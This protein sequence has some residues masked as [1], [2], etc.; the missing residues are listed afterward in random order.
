MNKFICNAL[1]ILAWPLAA[2]GTEYRID[3][4]PRQECWTEQV[5]VQSTGQGRGAAIVGGIAGGLLGNQIGGGSGRAAATAAGAIAGTIIGDRMSTTGTTYQSF[6]TVQR[7]RTVMDQVRVAVPEPAYY[8]PRPVVEQ[9]IYYLEQP[10]DWREERWRRA[11][12]RR[13]YWHRKHWKQHRDHDDDDLG[14][15]RHHRGRDDD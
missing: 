6:Q 15:G 3:E 2:Y 1:A 9:R 12:W 14:R 13:E 4:R 11:Q 5:P 10:E 7:C 8:P